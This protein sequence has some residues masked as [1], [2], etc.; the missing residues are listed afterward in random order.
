M[1]GPKLGSRS[2]IGPPDYRLDDQVGFMLRQAN[3]RHTAIFA[4]LMI[5]E[6]RPQQF[7]A[8]AKLYE[9][10]GATQSRLGRL[11]AMDGA[12]IKG[13]IDRLRERGLVETAPDPNDGRRLEVRLS[14]AGERVVRQA[15][16][17]AIRIT[18]ETLEPLDE[19]ERAVF[20]RLLAKLT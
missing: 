19:A 8:L 2:E 6:L 9:T 13:V 10:G 18:E 4:R 3:Q 17:A 12:T 16:P 1:N 20:L 11:T 5:E 14:A 15:L 7:A